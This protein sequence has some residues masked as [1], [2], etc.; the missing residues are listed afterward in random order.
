VEV[1]LEVPE[2]VSVIIL[3]RNN[4][5]QLYCNGTTKEL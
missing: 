5:D 4:W 1:A 3:W 2:D